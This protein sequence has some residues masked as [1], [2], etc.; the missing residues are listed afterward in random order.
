[1]ATLK[2]LKTVIFLGSAR[3]CKPPWGGD[4]RT[5]DRVLKWVKQSI[6]ARNA[7]LGSE[8]IKHEIYV[9]DPLEVFGQ[10]G[11]LA[12]IS[13]GELTVPT[14]F[15]KELPPK[16][17][18]LKQ[19]IANA[20]AFIIISPEYNHVAPPALSSIMG[21]FGGSLYKCKP[22]GIITYSPGPWGGMRAAMCIQVMNHELGCL[23]VSK[24]VGLPDVASLIK[25]DG[26]PVEP[27]AR[28]LKQLPEMLDQLEWMAV[29]MKRQRDETGVF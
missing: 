21:H 20:D 23:P 18:A 26:T 1:M 28:M 11:A 10:G 6:E 9:V 19:T 17:A 7:K 27:T 22:S 25:E 15:L 14:F 24:L 5:G 16:A 4:S 3:D 13:R 2:I 12:E 29:A 8:S